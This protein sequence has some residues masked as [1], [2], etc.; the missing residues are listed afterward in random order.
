MSD[1][2][3]VEQA[4]NTPDE[5]TPWTSLVDLWL[6]LG[7]ALALHVALRHPP[8]QATAEPLK[9]KAL[10][11]PE[12]VTEPQQP[13]LPAAKNHHCADAGLAQYRSVRIAPK[14][15]ARQRRTKPQPLNLEDEA[16]QFQR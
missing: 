4:I 3:E 8:T 6:N 1:L 9:I 12:L 11:M 7:M 2:E 14:R 5:P 10:E 15:A 13:T 16:G